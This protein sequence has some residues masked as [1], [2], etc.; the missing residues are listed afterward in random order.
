MWTIDPSF[1]GAAEIEDAHESV[2]SMLDGIRAG[3]PSVDR[4]AL[5]RLEETLVQRLPA[6]YEVHR[7]AGAFGPGAAFD[8]IRR[9]ASG[10]RRRFRNLNDHDPGTHGWWRVFTRLENETRRVFG[11]VEAEPFEDVG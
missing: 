6:L 8:E 5:R 2:E 4:R 7:R 10:W 1:P 3:H 9:F 11:E